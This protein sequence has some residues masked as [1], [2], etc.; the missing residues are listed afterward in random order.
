MKKIA[1]LGSTGSIGKQTVDVVKSNPDK[2]KIVALTANSNYELLI[3][4]ARELSP[5]YVVIG[6]KEYYNILQKELISTGIQVFAGYD[7]IGDIATA[8]EVNFVIVALVGYSALMPTIKAVKSRKSVALANKEALVVAGEII[9]KLAYEKGVQLLPIDSE[10]SAIFQCLQGE[11][12]SNIEKIYLTA[13][14][15]PFRNWTSTQLEY[16][17]LEQALNHP[18]WNMGGKI[19]VDSATMMNKGLEMIEAR[20]LFNLSPSQIK[21]IVHKQSIIHS[22][23]Q[24]VDGS[25]KAQLGLPDMRQAIQYAVSYPDRFFSDLERFSFDRYKEFNFEQPNYE[26]FRCLK[27]AIYALKE[28]GNIPCIMNAANEIAVEYFLQEKIKFVEI[29]IIIE[30][31][32]E[33]F[34]YDRNL[35]IQEYV[36]TNIEA[37]KIAVAIADNF[38]I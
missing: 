14:G 28:G 19:T 6:K 36:E 24:F 1:L 23:V 20:W 4:Q 3:Q 7:K 35:S 18:N 26:V 16:V 17:T 31:T 27:I 25:I 2:F 10:H 13:S 22:L 5:Q 9:T 21:V 11:D 34:K 15:G 30:R 32:I 38:G 33:K 37:R 29:P 8:S 12:Y